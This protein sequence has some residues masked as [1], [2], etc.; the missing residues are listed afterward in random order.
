MWVG[1][2]LASFE[3][4]ERYL[5]RAIVCWAL[6]KYPRNR[7]CGLPCFK[8]ITSSASSS[9]VLSNRAVLSNS[10]VLANCV[11]LLQSALVFAVGA[12]CWAG[13]PFGSQHAF[14]EEAQRLQTR[15][16]PPLAAVLAHARKRAPQVR[17]GEAALTVSQ[18]EFVNARRA[19]MHNP[20][21]EVMGQRG[22]RGTTK[23]IALSGTLWLPFEVFGQ[24]SGRIDEAQAY[25]GIFEANLDVAEATALGEAFATYGATQVEAERIRV[26]EQMVGLARRTAELY[27]SRLASGDAVLRDATMA[28]VELARNE[29]LL[30]E[31]HG[32]FA[33]ALTHL[34]RITGQAYASVE[35]PSLTLPTAKFDD[36]LTRVERRLPPA[37]TSA[38]AEVKYFESQRERLDRESLGPLQLML[39]GGRGDFGEARMGLGIAYEVPAVRALQGEKAR[40]ESEALRAQTQSAISRSIIERQVDGIAQQYRFGQSAYELLTNVALPAANNA[41]DSATA[42]LEAGKTDWF[43]VLLSR[44]DLAMLSLERLNVVEQQWSLLGELIQLTGELP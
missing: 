41:V 7:V 2:Q 32:R 12:L 43:A 31:A 19:P 34:S 26:I 20:Y 6:P 42:T 39:M 8:M 17:L 15:A 40:A 37:V 38:D 25:Q 36:Y 4:P 27:E 23:D 30:Q 24:R 16:V 21:F 10:A 35:A 5:S 9:A 22:T 29:V 1:N 33:L 11:T 14:A 44:R 18:T 3:K 28:K 13:A